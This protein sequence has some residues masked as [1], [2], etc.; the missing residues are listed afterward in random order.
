MTQKMTPRRTP[1]KTLRQREEELRALLAT[2]AGREELQ[3]LEARCR[4]EGG[5][6][7]PERASVVTYILVHERGRGLIA[8]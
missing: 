6:V 8:L 3:E 5:G 7:R 2:P 4:A 1:A